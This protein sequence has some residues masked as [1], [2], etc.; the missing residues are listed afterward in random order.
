MIFWAL[1]KETYKGTKHVMSEVSD[2]VDN[3]NNELSAYNQ[4][5]ELPRRHCAAEPLRRPVLR[6]IQSYPVIRASYLD[7]YHCGFK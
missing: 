4:E 7:K 1:L 2:G 6:I 5:Q 3:L